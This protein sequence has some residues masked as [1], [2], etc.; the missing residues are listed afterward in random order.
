M[1]LIELGERLWNGL[2]RP[3]VDFTTIV[4][5]VLVALAVNNW[6]TKRNE[7]Q[8]EV[9]YLRLL[10][11]DLVADTAELARIVGRWRLYESSGISALRFLNDG[12][13]G[14]DRPD[15]LV[16][17]FVLAGST[18]L[19]DVENATYEELKS[20]GSLRLLRDPEIRRSLIRYQTRLTFGDP[21]IQRHTHELRLLVH[22]RVPPEWR[23]TVVAECREAD[24]KL[25]R[26]T[27]SQTDFDPGAFLQS[28]R[29]DPNV[30][31]ALNIRLSDVIRTRE[32]METRY[33]AAIE[34]LQL[35]QRA[36]ER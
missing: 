30:R 13:T 17:A 27:P 20:S 5:G 7:R 4:V 14:L 23:R 29:A 2:R 32:I 31:G 35:L 10:S 28:L 11:A 9:E 8:L 34:T 18:T 19:P 15:C 26:S 12:K 25:R 16:A 1:Q 36:V 24:G 22:S 3:L 21:F 6:A 33:A